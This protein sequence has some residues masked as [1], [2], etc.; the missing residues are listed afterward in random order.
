MLN[1]KIIFSILLLFPLAVLAIDEMT[2]T[3]NNFEG[4]GWKLKG[5]TLSAQ[6]LSQDKPKLELK[7]QEVILNSLKQPLKN[8]SVSCAQLE[9]Q[10]DKI[11]CA[12]GNLQT[13]NTLLEKSNSILIFNYDLKQNIMNL[14]FKQFALAQGQL[15]AKVNTTSTAWEATINTE[16]LVL[17]ALEKKIQHFTDKL[18]HFKLKGLLNLNTQLS[19]KTGLEQITIQANSDKLNFESGT[20]L[21]AGQQLKIA[22]D[23]TLQP[24]KN[25]WQIKG[26]LDMKQ[27]ELLLDPVYVTFAKPAQLELEATWTANALNIS[28]IGYH[29]GDILNFEGYSELDLGKEFK[30]KEM[31]AR[32]DK[33]S[34][35]NLYEIYLKNWLQNTHQLELVTSGALQAEFG[36]DAQ[37]ST[38]TAQLDGVSLENSAKSWGWKGITGAIQWHSEEKDLLTELSWKEGYFGKV[39]LGKNAFKLYSTGNGLKLATPFEQPILDGAL[40]IEK[41]SLQNIGKSNFSGEIQPNLKQISMEKITQT[42]GLPTLKGQLRGALPAFHYSNQQLRA[43]GKVSFKAFDGDITLQGLNIEHLGGDAPTLHTDVEIQK[44]NLKMLTSMTNFGEIQG[45]LSGKISQLYLINWQP[46]SFDAYLATP[47]DNDLPRKISQK[48]V[49]SLSNLGGGGVVNVLSQGVLSLFEDFSY[50]KINGG[51]HLENKICYLGQTEPAKEGYYIVKGSGLPRIDV[52]GYNKEFNWDTLL[53][54]LKTLA[55]TGKPVIK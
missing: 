8:L 11:S 29:H 40:R 7:I 42:L 14:E 51:C 9:Y 23:T 10:P 20:G 31:F 25:A 4:E 18:P 30:I 54:R 33:T 46:V 37:N 16:K 45:R 28:N 39:N 15:Q 12:Q 2:L 27:G 3:L 41:F 6:A 50:E 49:N 32:I 24:L 48:A 22:F 44:L 19:G 26:K 5:V 43:Q 35:S 1:L 36:W 55:K 17:E 13:D 47:K 52:I 34:V 53:N 38:L 21:Q